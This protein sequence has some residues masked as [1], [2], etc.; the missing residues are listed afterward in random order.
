METLKIHFSVNGLKYTLLKRNEV[1]ALYVIGGEHT[2][3]I[4]HWE[5]CKIY[6]RKDQY[7]IREAL[8]TNEKF[9]RDYSRCFID[10]QKALE[11]YDTLSAA[12]N[13]GKWTAKVVTVYYLIN[14]WLSVITGLNV[15]FKQ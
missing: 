12:L 10:K 7:G 9:G 5:V 3:K 6:I 2:E 1:V 4:L 15:N 11:Y 13:R 14:I 8:P